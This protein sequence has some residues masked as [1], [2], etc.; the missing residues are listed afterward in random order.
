[1]KRTYILIGDFLT[2]IIAIMATLTIVV[3]IIHGNWFHIFFG[4]VEGLIARSMFNGVNTLLEDG[5]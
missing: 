1:M 4:V 2:I 5:E 3:G